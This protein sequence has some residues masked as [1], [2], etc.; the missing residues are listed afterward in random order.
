MSLGTGRGA[1]GRGRSAVALRFLH[2]DT[3]L[4]AFGALAAGAALGSGVSPAPLQRVG[5]GWGALMAGTTRGAHTALPLRTLALGAPAEASAVLC[6]LA[7]S[8]ESGRGFADAAGT[9]LGP[10]VSPVPQ[11]TST[12]ARRPGPLPP[13]AGQSGVGG[14]AGDTVRD[15]RKLCSAPGRAG[16]DAVP[17]H[18]H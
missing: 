17:L 12:L 1:Q 6:H 7:G 14:W 3:H 9:W 4:L 11:V 15:P 5:C 16:G 18:G 10:A 13:E 2:L 8:R